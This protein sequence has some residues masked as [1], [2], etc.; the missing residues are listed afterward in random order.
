MSKIKL[1]IEKSWLVVVSSLL[2]G[3]VL[4]FAN[5]SWQG[6]IEANELE[7]VKKNMRALVADAN[8]F[9]AVC[10]QKPLQITEK[11]SIKTDIYKAVDSDGKTIGF[12][13]T[14]QGAGFADKIKLVIAVDATLK[15]YLGY[16]VLSS[17]ETPGFGDKIDG[18]KNESEPFNSRFEDAPFAKLEVVKVDSPSRKNKEIIAITGATI[19][20][21]AVVSIFNSYRDKV[22]EKLEAEGL[23]K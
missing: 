18:E 8:D 5:F 7:K 6:K 20:S 1:F 23:L 16:K 22:K 21:D 11:K 4:G 17:N 13:Y 15:K 9:V 12:A 10:I 14:A 2:F 3:L 19:S